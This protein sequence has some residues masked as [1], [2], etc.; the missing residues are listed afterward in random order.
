MNKC[1]KQKPAK[2]QKNDTHI[3]FFLTKSSSEKRRCFIQLQELQ[4]NCRN[5]YLAT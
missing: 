3:Y 2:K 4:A 5:F 1:R